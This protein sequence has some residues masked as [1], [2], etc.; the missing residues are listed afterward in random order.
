PDAQRSGFFARAELRTSPPC[1]HRRRQPSGVRMRNAAFAPG[2]TRV[3]PADDLFERTRCTEFAPE[4]P[5]P[6]RIGPAEIGP[7]NP[8]YVI[9]EAGVNH[10]GHV[11]VAKELIH[12]ATDAEADAIKFQVFSADRLVTRSAPT[13]GYQSG[14]SSDGTQHNMLSR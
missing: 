3:R 1:V 10:D 11:G 4:A 12:A 14:C 9:A 6:L 7:G 13:A 5:Q 8:V 2:L